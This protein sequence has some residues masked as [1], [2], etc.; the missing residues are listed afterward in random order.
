MADPIDSIHQFV[1]EH[2][3]RYGNITH[4]PTLGEKAM[5]EDA[6]HK[7]VD[8]QLEWRSPETAPMDGTIIELNIEYTNGHSPLHDAI[9]APTIG[10]NSFDDTGDDCWEIVG[11]DWSQ[12]HIRNGRGKILGWRSSRLNLPDPTTVKPIA[13]KG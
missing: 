7:W 8:K 13:Q 5:L 1:N 12:D 4:S 6:L 11:W 3:F 2:E 10:W 9:V